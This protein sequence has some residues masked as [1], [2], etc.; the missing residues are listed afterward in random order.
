MKNYG[1]HE[2]QKQGSRILRGSPFRGV[3]TVSLSKVSRKWDKGRQRDF[4][5]VNF[6]YTKK[7]KEENSGKYCRGNAFITHHSIEKQSSWVKQERK[8]AWG[9]GIVSVLCQIHSLGLSIS[10]L[11]GDF[12]IEIFIR[13]YQIYLILHSSRMSW[14]CKVIVSYIYILMHH[15]HHHHSSASGVQSRSNA[16]LKTLRKRTQKSSRFSPGFMNTHFDL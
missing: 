14:K 2:K 12:R 7:K 3:I 1:K 4:I 10:V 9:K 11:H 16:T 13:V 6:L 15:H 5:L 8:A